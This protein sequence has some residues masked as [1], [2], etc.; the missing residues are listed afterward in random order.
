M[1]NYLCLLKEISNEKVVTNA[2]NTIIF[3]NL[4]ELCIEEGTIGKNMNLYEVKPL[5]DMYIY[6]AGYK[7]ERLQ[8]VKKICSNDILELTKPFIKNSYAMDVMFSNFNYNE[9]F[10]EEY[11]EFSFKGLDSMQIN[12]NIDGPFERS[13]I[14]LSKNQKLSESFIR[15]FRKVLHLYYVYIYQKNISDEFREDFVLANMNWDYVPYHILDDDFIIKFKDKLDLLTLCRY[16][17][18][19][20]NVIE[21]CK[22]IFSWKHWKYISGNTSI[23]ETILMNNQDK[24]HWDVVAKRDNLS[25]LFKE[26]FKDKLN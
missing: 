10:L 16:N 11:I 4:F 8:I 25:D 15:K 6:N 24:I 19:S 22:S 23:S 21:K 1:S 18:V 5:T 17:K 20:A 7:V 3:D 9:D 13:V 12:Y 2:N 14:K 26:M